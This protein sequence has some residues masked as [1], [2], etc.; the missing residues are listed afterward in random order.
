MEVLEAGF[1]VIEKDIEDLEDSQI[2]DAEW[3]LAVEDDI[4][5]VENAV[6]GKK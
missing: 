1:T 4:E 6:F 3:F 5:S 2:L